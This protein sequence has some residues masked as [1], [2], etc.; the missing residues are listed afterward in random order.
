M[1]E[2]DGGLAADV[3]LRPPTQEDPEPTATGERDDVAARF[4]PLLAGQRQTDPSWP[5]APEAESEAAGSGTAESDAATDE[6][7]DFDRELD[8]DAD[9]APPGEL[10]AALDE[11]RRVLEVDSTAPPVRRRRGRRLLVALAAV[12]VLVAAALVI[13]HQVN[14]RV[15]SADVERAVAGQLPPPAVHLGSPAPSAAA[16]T[17]ALSTPQPTLAPLE[18]QPSVSAPA[19]LPSTG[20][21]ITEPGTYI[22]AAVDSGPDADAVDVYEQVVFPGPGLD[23]LPLSLVPASSLQADLASARLQV[24]DLQVALDG[25]VA[26]AVPTGANTWA[27]TAVQGGRFTKAQLR[28]CAAPRRSPGGPWW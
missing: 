19:S 12:L 10:R 16:T 23:S 28:S 13:R 3:P 8:G 5:T 24:T 4:R 15:S 25:Q 2:R 11:L 7:H 17:P 1:A 6:A 14:S 18:P 20:P 9:G 27:A 22:T 26:R 21:G